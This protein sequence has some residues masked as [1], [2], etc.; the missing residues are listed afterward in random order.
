MAGDPVSDPRIDAFIAAA[1]PFARPI[2]QHLRALVHAEVPGAGE[3]IKWNSPHFTWQGKN[4]ARMNAFKAHCA[5]AIHGDG[6]GERGLGYIRI[7]TL[8]ELPPRDALAARLRA[9]CARIAQNG[10]PYA[11]TPRA[12]APSAPVPS[13]FAAALAVHPAAQA[14]F[15]AFSPSARREYVL[16]IAEAKRAETRDRRIAHAV[17]WIA[18]GKGRNWKYEKR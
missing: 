9:A 11:A 7:A 14:H 15:T 4:L 8:E 6:E 5:F 18:E 3:A 13:A 2:L 16:W 10:S 1:R 12:P 17:E